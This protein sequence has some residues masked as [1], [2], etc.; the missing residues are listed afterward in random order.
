MKP[1]KLPMSGSCRCGRVKFEIS[2][3]PMMTAACHCSGCQR[4][5]SSAYS[6]TAI[7]PAEGFRVTEGDTVIGG[8]KGP[9]LHH[10]FCPDC[11]TWMF[12]RIEGY[13]AMVNV[14]PTLLEDSSWFTPFIETVTAEK[15][16]WATTPARHSYEGFPA[17]EE[18]P[19][20][21][22]EYEAAGD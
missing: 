15:L 8:L 20:L 10:H 3:P 5:S 12:T 21:M 13:E 1:K 2:Q 6:L 19:K 14:R 11:M 18:L 22:A 16:P 17:M 7:M 9:E 4:M